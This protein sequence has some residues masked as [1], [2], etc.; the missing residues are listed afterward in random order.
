MAEGLL[1]SIVTWGF[2]S[3][4]VMLVYV[5]ESMTVEARNPVSVTNWARSTV[6]GRG[7]SETLP[8]CSTALV[9]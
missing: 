5:P 3:V 6:T 7:R 4:I 1:F 9:I 2:A 8:G